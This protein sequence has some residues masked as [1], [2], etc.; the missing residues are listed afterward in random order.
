METVNIHYAKT[1]LS[2][3]IEAVLNGEEV[4]IAKSGEPKVK[5]VPVLKKK[6]KRKPGFLKGQIWLADDW[7]SPETNKEIEDLFYGVDDEEG[8]A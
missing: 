7:D 2:K 5:L 1:H 3:L 4:I 6:K 8:S